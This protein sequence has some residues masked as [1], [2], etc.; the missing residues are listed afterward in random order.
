MAEE[1][2][3]GDEP[4]PLLMNIVARHGH[5]IV[6]VG[7]SEPEMQLLVVAE[8][9]WANKHTRDEIL[10]NLK[11]KHSGFDPAFYDHKNTFQEDALKCFSRHSRPKDGCI[12]WH[13]DSKRLTPGN[14]KK[15]HVF[16]C[17]FCPVASTV[18]TMIRSARGDYDKQP[19]EVD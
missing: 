19:G 3:E 17:D 11:Q 14:W 1:P 16:L 8:K 18:T 6:E 2:R 10:S 5:P 12:D 4:D 13:D 15:A 9:D 7:G